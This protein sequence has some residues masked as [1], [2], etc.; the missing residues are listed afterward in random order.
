MPS[1]HPI[2]RSS[3]AIHNRDL[4]LSQPIQLIDQRVYLPVGGLDPPPGPSGRVAWWPGG[5]TS[6]REGAG[7]SNLINAFVT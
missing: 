1:I 3:P 7:S 2:G 4:L 6:G 5:A